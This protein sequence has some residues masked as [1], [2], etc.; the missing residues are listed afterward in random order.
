M[1]LRLHTKD[2]YFDGSV[3]RNGDEVKWELV[4]SGSSVGGK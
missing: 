4:T 3:L 2:N 1:L